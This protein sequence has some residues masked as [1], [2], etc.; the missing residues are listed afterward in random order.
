MIPT[1]PLRRDS[2]KP[3]G[4]P[5]SSK[6]GLTRPYVVSLKTCDYLALQSAGVWRVRAGSF[7]FEKVQYCS[8]DHFKPACEET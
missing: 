2:G 5:D 8:T 7:P 3:G 6:E 1:Y 4:V